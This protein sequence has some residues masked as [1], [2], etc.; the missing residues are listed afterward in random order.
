MMDLYSQSLQSLRYYLD[1]SNVI[2][3]I[4]SY[5][6]KKESGVCNSKD[7][8]IPSLS[9]TRKIPHLLVNLEMV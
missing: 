6:M 9:Y 8:I 4:D 3:V 5:R 7:K 1:S 2:H